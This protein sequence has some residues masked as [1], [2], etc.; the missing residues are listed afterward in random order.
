M[1]VIF[2]LKTLGFLLLS[3]ALHLT[4]IFYIDFTFL[5]DFT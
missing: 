1:H 2:S 3:E 5:F 4:E